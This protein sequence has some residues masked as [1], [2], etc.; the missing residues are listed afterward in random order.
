MWSKVLGFELTYRKK[1]PATYLYFLIF[2]ILCFGAITSDNVTIGAASEKVFKN[3]PTVIFNYV[4]LMSA[5]GILVAS[6][7]MGVPLYRD[8]EFK[9]DKFYF[10][11]PLK[12]K[13][14]L[15]GRFTGSFIVLLF[16]FSS[17]QVAIL[18]GSMMPW[19]NQ[20]KIGPIMWG[21]H[22][23]AF[24]ILLVPNLLFTGSIFFSLVALTRRIMAAYTGSVILLV[25]Y[26]ISVNFTNDLDKKWLAELLDPFAFTSVSEITRYWSIF[27]Q[28]NNLLPFSGGLLYNRILWT[29]VSLL[30]LILSFNRFSFSTFKELGQKAK[31]QA[32]DKIPQVSS[33]PRIEIPEIGAATHFKQMLSLSWIELKNAVSNPYFISILFAGGVFLFIDCFLPNETYGTP[34]MPVTYY[35]VESKNNNFVLFVLIILIYYSG[36]MIYK[37]RSLKLDQ[38]IDALPIPNWMVYGSKL[39]AMFYIC[40][41]LASTVIFIGVLVQTIKGYFNYE[42]GLYFTDMY[43]LTLPFYFVMAIFVFFIMILVNN[44]FV[45]FG[46]ILLYWLARIG[47]TLMDYDHNMLYVGNRPNYIYS[48]MNGFGHYLMPL[49]SFT[50][51]WLSF[52]VILLVIGNVYWPR[53]V[54]AGLKERNSLAKQRF[55]SLPKAAIGLGFL[56]WIGFGAWILYN[57]NFLNEYKLG[58][59]IEKERAEFEKKYKGWENLAQP[60]IYD[61]KL[62]VEI[63][64]AD[65]KADIIGVFKLTNNTGKRID[66]LLLNFRDFEKFKQ[67]KIAGKLIQ[68]S[69]T[70]ELYNMAIFDLEEPIEI[71]DSLK[72]EF[73][74]YAQYR[75]FTNEIPPSALNY[76]GSFFRTDWLPSFG[77]NY[78][79]ELVSDETRKE[80]GLEPQVT[81]IPID[82]PKYKYISFINTGADYVQLEVK[83]GTDPD[84]I[85]V[86]SGYLQKTW[87][88]NG[89]RY[90]HYKTEAPGFYYFGILSARYE[91]LMD[92]WVSPEG[93]SVNLEIYYL[94]GHDKNLDRMMKGMK[95][96]LDYY[97]RNFS[98]YQHSQ[99]RIL[100][101]PRYSRFAQSFANTVPYSE[102]FGFVSDFSDEDDIDYAFYVTAH[103]V[104]HQ[105]WAH[106]VMPRATNGSSTVSESMSQYSALMVMEKEYGPDKISKFLEYELRSYLSGRAGE[107]K[108]EPTLLNNEGQGYVHYRKGSLAMYSIKDYLGEEKL[109]TALKKYVDSVAF[110]AAPFTSSLELYE[111]I[112]GAAPDSLKGFIDDLFTRRVLFENRVKDA[113]YEDLGDGTY[114]V[115]LDLSMNKFYED[116]LGMEI[117]GPKVP[118][119]VDIGIFGSKKINGQEIETTLYLKKHKFKKGEEKLSIVV[120]GKPEEAGIDPY[121]KLVDRNPD[122]NKTVVSEKGSII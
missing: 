25:A 59:T 43:L 83:V 63:Y 73:E 105:W 93:K 107:N 62:D 91:I 10:S 71:N 64:P 109:N 60:K 44:K 116:S 92:T 15:L 14:Y 65:R 17:V 90:F 23:Q 50:G 78:G 1:R 120:N 114:R 77:Y 97:S 72:M 121:I 27:Q 94:K 48:D 32:L 110:Q 7:V 16:I 87:E 103:E 38:I 34:A 58:D 117:D 101:F 49:L 21:A 81:S 22:L 61:V 18:I 99:L 104:G 74:M 52:S 100:E 3:S 26:I 47:L 86:V 13:D 11:L 115:T 98:P 75:G 12:E 41:I 46:V 5:F 80:Y 6:A 42:F 40:F 4:I 106:Q 54:V 28:N 96:S 66:T 53:G 51:Y 68:P 8:I 70:S 102:A 112:K 29:S 45:G 57:T 88:E 119:W 79:K 31:A 67:L 30:L 35:M 36:E 95:N 33:I 76:N 108:Y 39:L 118:D 82:D 85:A 111:H 20:D 113:E 69:W 24:F 9:T 84:Q 55:G 89:R 37:E 19:V 56:I 2:F 122:D